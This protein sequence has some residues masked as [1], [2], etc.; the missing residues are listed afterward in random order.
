MSSETIEKDSKKKLVAA[1]AEDAAE[2]DEDERDEAEDER[3][4]AESKPAK[5]FVDD[6]HDSPKR[7]IVIDR[8]SSAKMVWTLTKREIG[9]YLNSAITYIVIATSM[10][11]IGWYFFFYKGGFWQVDRASMTRMFDALPLALCFLTI[12]LFTM[13]SLSDEKRVGT[14]E[15]L[16]TMPVKDSEVI[17]GKFFGSLAMVSLQ[18]LLLAAYPLVMFSR[19]PFWHLGE[20]DW[21]PFWVGML[22]LF[23]LS[24]AG[25]ALGVMWSSFT[26]SQILSYFATMITLVALYAIGFSTVVEFLQGWPGDAIAFVSLH[27]RFEPFARGLIDSRAVI[28]FLSLTTL[29]LVVAFRSLESRKWS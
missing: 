22:G 8:P 6:S 9:G 1:E 11:A 27:S 10:V 3:D 12:P 16:I 17:L 23:L 29:G 26:E 28:Y 18:I 2:R 15:L 7:K 14:I 24:A 4:E 13:R 19:A 21:S 25:T 20:L 5:S